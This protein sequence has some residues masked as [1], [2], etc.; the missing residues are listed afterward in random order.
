[1]VDLAP[2]DIA[3]VLLP[4]EPQRPAALDHTAALTAAWD[5]LQHLGK[6]GASPL[7]HALEGLQAQ[8][9]AA[10]QG[11]KAAQQPYRGRDGGGHSWRTAAQA[12]TSVVGGLELL[13]EQ[14][15]QAAADIAL[16]EAGGH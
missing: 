8:C 12:P 15:R 11:A 7:L 14:L 16:L 9:A 2:D 13:E 5:A 1:M 3:A 6:G 10:V 4:A